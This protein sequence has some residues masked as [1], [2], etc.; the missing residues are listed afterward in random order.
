[1][2]EMSRIYWFWF[3]VQIVILIVAAGTMWAVVEHYL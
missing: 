1:M 2:S 3:W